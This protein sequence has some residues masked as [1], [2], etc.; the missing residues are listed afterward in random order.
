MIYLCHVKSTKGGTFKEETCSFSWT[1]WNQSS[2][3]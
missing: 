1:K 2:R 3:M